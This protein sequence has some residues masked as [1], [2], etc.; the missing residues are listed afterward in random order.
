MIRSALLLCATILGLACSACTAPTPVAGGPPPPPPPVTCNAGDVNSFVPSKVSVLDAAGGWTPYPS[1]A[2][3]GYGE[4]PKL[5][6][7]LLAANTADDLTQ[8]F[9]AAPIFFRQQLCGLDSVFVD[10]TPC[11][12]VDH[13]SDRS[14]GYRD[15][16]S[17]KMYIG[18]SANGLW[19][20]GTHAPVLTQYETDQLRWQLW[21]L[22]GLNWPS[23]GPY[24]SSR[25]GQPFDPGRPLDT[26]PAVTSAMTVLAALAHELGHVRW[27]QLNV[28]IPG[29]FEYDF[30]HTL[31]PCQ[32]DTTTSFFD[33]SWDYD[34]WA[35][36]PPKWRGAVALEPRLPAHVPAH[37][38]LPSVQATTNPGTPAALGTTLASLYNRGHPWASLL[39]SLTPDHDFVETHVF[40]VL[41]RNSTLGDPVAHPYVRSLELIVP[42]AGGVT[43]AR[44]VPDDYFNH[45]AAKAAFVSKVACV[46]WL[47]D[48]IPLR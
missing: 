21:R 13:C 47:N 24:F 10:P 22:N 9:S 14:W 28:K 33:D 12:G 5:L 6:G 42:V 16:T 7:G 30:S 35:L 40:D 17:G 32:N 20:G 37:V 18:L 8:A 38:S 41:T 31:I 43:V 11:S 1:G 45:P 39:A 4:P 15:P 2:N 3:P 46:A 29:S 27:Y 34:M 26:D 25:Y 44:D 23:G 19:P 36:Q 48:H